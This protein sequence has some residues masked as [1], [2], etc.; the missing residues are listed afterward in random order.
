MDDE[1]F[2][3]LRKSDLVDNA[4]VR[5]KEFRTT[6]TPQWTAVWLR[7]GTAWIALIL[8]NLFLIYVPGSSLSI[9]TIEVAFAATLIGFILAYLQLFIHE[10][11]HYNLYPDP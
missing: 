3:R 10:A 2:L 4:G 5:F 11:A 1:L 8:C 7:I 6:L 9:R